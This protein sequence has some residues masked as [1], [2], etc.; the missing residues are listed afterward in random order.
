MSRPRSFRQSMAWLHTWS[1]LVVGWVLFAI[2]VTGTASYYRTEI[3]HWMRPELSETAADPVAA[4]TRAGTFLQ[5][6][7]PDA[8]AWSIRLPSAESPAVTVYWWRSFAG[9]FHHALLDPATGERASVRDTHGGN[10]LYRF[11]YELNLPPIWGRWIVSACAMNLLIALISGI[12]THRRIFADFFTFRRAR[13]A[14]RGWLD[15]HNVMGVLA[16][17][18][19]LMI[20]YTGLVTLSSM[21]MPWAVKTAYHGDILRYYADAGI[22]VAGR[23]PVGRPGQALPLGEIV[24]RA[25]AVMGETPELMVVSHP[26]DAAATATVY[27]EEPPGLAHLHPQIAY[28]AA[29]GAE[30]GRVGE[31]GAATR[32]GAVMVGLHEAHFAAAPL[33]LLFFLCGLMGA[34]AVA[35]GLVLWTVARVPKKGAPE[36]LGLRFVRILNLGTIAGLPAGLAAYFLAN[37]LLPA[38]LDARADREVGAFFAVWMLAALASALYP[39]PLAWPIALA[40]PGFAF[41]A[42]PGVDALTVG[43]FRFIGFDIAM[44]LL[45]LLLLL[46]ARLAGRRVLARNPAQSRLHGTAEA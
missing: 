8:A 34:A 5:K 44:A 20:V 25:V 15:A 31:A 24:S 1:G 10:F 33:R 21:L 22:L 39:R 23:P 13:S 46:A 35:T 36:G 27:F 29:T 38:G 26:G 16:L 37:R 3:S 9:P 17:P 6:T 11:H 7:M 2:F 43:E 19:H 42:I 14:Q 30:L 32:T 4:A 12:V 41:L 40:V 45:G 28:D 18:F